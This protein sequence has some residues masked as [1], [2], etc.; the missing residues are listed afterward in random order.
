MCGYLDSLGKH[1]TTQ[2]LIV[3]KSRYLRPHCPHLLIPVVAVLPADDLALAPFMMLRNG[4]ATCGCVAMS[5][6]LLDAYMAC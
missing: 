6:V 3:R 1:I 2:R 5:V 4:S